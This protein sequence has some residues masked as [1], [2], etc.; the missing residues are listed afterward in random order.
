MAPLVGASP[1]LS[2]EGPFD[3]SQ[4]ASVSGPASLVLDNLPGC[5]Y[6][7]TSYEATNADPA[8]GLQLHNPW[9]LEYVRVPESAYWLQHMCRVFPLI[10]VWG[11]V[12]RLVIYRSFFF[13][14]APLC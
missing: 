3:V 1:D 4:G 5:Q 7:M 9:F 8:Y 10:L 13:R 6:R 2:R 11:W 12:T 14:V